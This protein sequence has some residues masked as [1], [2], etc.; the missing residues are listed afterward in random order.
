[1]SSSSRSTVAASSSSLLASLPGEIIQHIAFYIALG[2]SPPPPPPP[3]AAAFSISSTADPL[4]LLLTTLQGSTASASITGGSSRSTRKRKEQ[5]PSYSSSSSLS[6]STPPLPGAAAATTTTLPRRHRKRPKS[7]HSPARQTSALLL[8][9][10]RHLLAFLLTCK[11][12]HAL[13]NF[14]ANPAFY[15]RLFRFHYDVQ[16]L[17]RRFGPRALLPRALAQEYRHRAQRNIEISAIVEQHMSSSS[18]P[19]SSRK[20]ADADHLANLWHI[21]LLLIEN[22]GKNAHVIKALQPLRYIDALASRPWLPLYQAAHTLPPNTAAHALALHIRHLLAPQP[23]SQQARETLLL[24]LRPFVFAAHKF[25]AFLAPWTYEHLPLGPAARANFPSLQITAEEEGGAAGGVGGEE[26]LERN[27]YLAD[28]TPRDHAFAIPYCGGTLRLAPPNP[29]HAACQIFFRLIELDQDPAERDIPGGAAFSSSSNHMTHLL[30][31]NALNEAVVR[32]EITVEQLFETLR[33][34]AAA[35]RAS[36]SSSNAAE[37]EL[38]ATLATRIATAAV[39]AS[40]ALG[41]AELTPA[42]SNMLAAIMDEISSGVPA[43]R[44]A[45]SSSSE[46]EEHQTQGHSGEKESELDEEGFVEGPSSS[47]QAEATHHAAAQSSSTAAAA[48]AEAEAPP[49]ASRFLYAVSKANHALSSLSP[50][51]SGGGAL[52]SSLTYDADFHRLQRTQ[53]PFSSPGLPPL[54]YSTQFA[55]TWEGRFAFFDFDSYREMLSG[56]MGGLFE[57][58]YGEQAQVWKLE[59]KVVRVRRK[60]VDVE[61]EREV[62]WRWK[63]GWDGSELDEE[64]EEGKDEGETRNVQRECEDEGEEEID[65]IAICG[66][67]H[68]A[69]GCFVL[70]GRVRPWDGMVDL[71]KEYSP[72]GRGRWRYRGYLVAGERLVGRWRDMFSPATMIGYEGCFLMQ[73]REGGR[74]VERS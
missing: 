21:Y 42:Q 40:A 72:D 36:S 54:T 74:V 26:E 5:L 15:A 67:G 25:D 6:A 35:V 30:S 65:E 17:A 44:R 18:I 47:A 61:R 52:A 32:G 60:V 73:R 20:L 4:A 16:P 38:V 49:T 1:M 24:H 45:A 59:E 48:A 71:T 53:S 70:K 51:S 46:E 31:A 37:A 66:V 57:G 50:S 12:F 63:G 3:A 43:S 28:L 64:E 22:D 27:P 68:S 19:S 9:Y 39:R 55:G 13:C 2:A 8:A 62:R 34:I 11:R 56:R 23:A 58:Q 33:R 7:S 69:W 41:D 29:V 10:P 14:D